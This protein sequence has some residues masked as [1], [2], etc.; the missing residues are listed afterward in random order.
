MDVDGVDIL[1][2]EVS[3]SSSESS[4]SSWE[5]RSTPFFF[6][7]S[8]KSNT[9]TQKI[10]SPPSRRLLTQ[11]QFWLL[12]TVLLLL[13][14]CPSSSSSSFSSSSPLQH[15][16]LSPLSP[17]PHPSLAETRMACSRCEITKKRK[18]T[19]VASRVQAQVSRIPHWTATLRSFLHS[20]ACCC[21]GIA[22]ATRKM[23][24]VVIFY[25]FLT[26]HLFQDGVTHKAGER[27]DT[28]SGAGGDTRSLCHRTQES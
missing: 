11:P 27:M 14:F 25:I 17:Q 5:Q 6:C 8:G 1:V 7:C 3:S 16:Q 21:S 10:I 15:F 22:P 12:L 24:N 4:S 18:P 2:F 9:V 26:P 23:S 28:F 20:N 13:W 19:S